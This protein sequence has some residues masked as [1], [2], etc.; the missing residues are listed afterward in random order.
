MIPTLEKLCYAVLALIHIIPASMLFRPQMI[1]KLYKAEANGPL[2]ALVHHRAA[3]FAVVVIACIWAMADPGV[4]RLAVVVIA[5]SM[6][7]FLAVYWHAGSP[8]ALKSIA[9]A[10]MVGLP[11]LAFAGWMAFWR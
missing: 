2:L 5:T 3:L 1:A 4:R 10:D 8:A 7:S 11:F 6:L 9:M